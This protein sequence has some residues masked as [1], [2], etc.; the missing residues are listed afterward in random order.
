MCSFKPDKPTSPFSPRPA[1]SIDIATA[2]GLA[3][4][5]TEHYAQYFK[6]TVDPE[7]KEEEYEFDWGAL[8]AVHKSFLDS[9]IVEL[10]L[11]SS[12]IPKLILYQLLGRSMEESPKDR[13]NFS[14]AVVMLGS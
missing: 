14:Q 4:A 6:T 13:K 8:K 10:C 7:T 5:V 1:V 3:K 9:I 12:P 2:R 11:P